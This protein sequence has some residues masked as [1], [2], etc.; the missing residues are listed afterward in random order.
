MGQP[1]TLPDGTVILDSPVTLP[2][3]L[4]LLIAGGGP[5]GTAAA[6]RAKELGLHALVIDYDDLMKRIRDYAKDKLILPDFG[7]GDRM[8]FPMGGELVTQLHFA[9]LDKDRMCQEWKGLFRRNNVPAQVGVEF[10]GLER[11]DD[12]VW[13]VRAWNHGTKSEAGYL[14]RHVLLAFGRGVP[15]RLDI[16]GNTEGLAFQLTEAA[17]YVGVPACVIGGGTSAA[18]AVIAISDAKAR[19]NDPSAVFWSYRGDKMPKVSKALADVFFASYVGNGNVR[20]LPTSEPVSIVAADDGDFL[21]IRTDRKVVP[22]RPRETVH[23]EFPKLACIACIGEDIPEALLGDIGAPLVTGGPANKKRIAV[24]PLLETRLPNVYLAGD[25]L[26]PAYLETDD[27]NTDPATWRELKRRG[28]IKAAMRD[29]VLVA[30]V[31]AQKVAGKTQI[32]VELQFAD[33]PATAP[34]ASTPTAV[35]PSGTV[36]VAPAAAASPAAP[37]D[38][39]APTLSKVLPTGVDAEEFTIR[40]TGV[41]TIGRRSCDVNFPDD[42]QLSDRHAS[43]TREERGYV[44][45]DEGSET[46]VYLRPANGV[47]VELPVG[48]VVRVGQQWLLCGDRGA[49]DQVVHYDASGNEAGRYQIRGTMVL[50]RQAPDITLDPNDTTMSRRHLSLSMKDG[51]MMLRDLNSANGTVVKVDQPMP[52]HDD[53]IIWIG[54]QVL[55]FDTEDVAR[56]ATAVTSTAVDATMAA[57]GAVPAARGAAASAGATVAHAPAAAPAAAGNCVLFQNTGAS[58]PVDGGKTIC[59]LAEHLGVSIVAECHQGICGSDPIKIISG[60]DNLNAITDA[61]KGTLED[62]CSLAPGQHRL[63]CMARAKGP[64]VV[65]VI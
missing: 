29:G 11:T 4:D 36:T 60:A 34:P 24:T 40:R 39:S 18:E 62:I 64:V 49:R 55:R 54:Q 65:E 52:L 20:Y 14:A 61:E 3:V 6:F 33:G 27:F 17:R 21:C 47:S 44:L 30:E 31:V 13:R 59:E 5:L 42:P 15:R 43:I 35:R 23:L 41:T 16:P 28:N 2:P 1:E 8:K 63:A 53:A 58:A 10:T 32:S 48:A 9:P 56:P 7:G 46:G 51:R 38:D 50:G 26:S 57:T 45:R 19:A 37:V 22:D 25:T 12:G